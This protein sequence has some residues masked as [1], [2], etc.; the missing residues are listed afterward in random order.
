MSFINNIL[1]HYSWQ[2][3]ALIA[4]LLIL[5]LVQ[6]YY[7]G[8]A[9]RNVYRYRLMR[10]RKQFCQNPAISVIVVARGEDETFLTTELPLL[11]AQQY[12]K[13]EVVVV[14]VGGDMNYFSELKLLQEE[15]MHMRLTRMGGN[16][17]IYITTKQALNVGIKSAQNNCLLFTT[18]GATP[19]D[20]MWVETMSRGFERGS[21]VLAPAVPYFEKNSTKTYLM[22][23][24]E[25]HRS[26]NAMAMAVAGDMYWAPRSNFGFTRDLYNSTRGFDHLNLDLGENDLYLL[27]I[28][29][30]ER[31]AVVMSSHSITTERRS[32]EWREW[33]DLM[34]Y[35]DYTRHYYPTRIGT[36]ARWESGSRVLF[37]FVALATMAIM[38]LEV[39]LAAAALVILRYIVVVY[40]ARR[41]ARKL[42]ER[43]VAWRYWIYDLLG[44]AVEWLIATHRSQKCAS[45]W[46]S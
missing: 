43:N 33:I 29:K 40:V 36:F 15:N 13:Y 8:I 5:F 21:V 2:G 11:L 1:E 26:L 30:P 23:M 42:G 41:V 38:P 4:T 7:Y 9:Y 31:T 3:V 19:R 46:R 6:L 25:L 22:R 39:A 17:R 35:Y 14:Y 18:P 16:E 37:L 44:P 27:T 12:D 24:T 28:A 10:S 45:A 34:R 20:D 32:D